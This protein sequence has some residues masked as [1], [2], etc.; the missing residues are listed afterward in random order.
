MLSV[1]IT[2]EQKVKIT[3]APRTASG[4]AAQV[5]GA[6]RVSVQSGDV[7]IESSAGE[8]LSFFAISGDDPGTSVLLV[9]AD[10]DLGSGEVLIADT[11]EV[12]VSGAQAENFGLVAGLAEP[13]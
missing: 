2:N 5:D 4:R 6:L 7:T 12:V 11:V 3:A 1:A 13:K 9:E 8:P 10:A